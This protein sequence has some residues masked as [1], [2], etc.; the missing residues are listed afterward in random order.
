VPDRCRTRAV[1]SDRDPGAFA[2]LCDLG[3]YFFGIGSGASLLFAVLSRCLPEA[4][5]LLSCA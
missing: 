4:R 2:L 5:D 1:Q 3:V